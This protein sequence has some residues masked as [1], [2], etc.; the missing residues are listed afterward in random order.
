V[1]RPFPDE[2]KIKWSE[3]KLGARGSAVLTSKQRALLRTWLMGKLKLSYAAIA[4]VSIPTMIE[5]YND[6][7]DSKLGALALECKGDH[8]T[9]TKTETKTE[10]KQET[11]TMP[12]TVT[13]L[14]VTLDKTKEEALRILLAGGMTEAQVRVIARQE[15]EKV[16]GPSNLVV[17]KEKL[18]GS[19]VEYKAGIAHWKLPLFIKALEARLNVALIGPAGTG[20]TTSAEIA[21]EVLGLPYEFT[22]ACMM[23][24]SLMGFLTATGELAKTAFYRSFVEKGGIHLMDEMD[25]WE[26]PALLAANAALANGRASFPDRLHDKHKDFLAVAGMNTIGMGSNRQY[27]GRKAL[28]ASTLDRFAYLDWPTDSALTASFVGVKRPQE[29][30]DLL[31]GGMMTPSAW[32]DRVNAVAGAVDKLGLRHLVTPRA[33]INGHKLFTVGV[34]RAWVEEM[35]LWKGLDSDSRTKV[36]KEAK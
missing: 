32:L 29:K 34:G 17:I 22:G 1:A 31:L 15:A 24:S 8:S 10:T 13:E 23:P 25:S 4:H 19:K 36:E 35:V 26:A 18:D 2:A 12:E 20:K 3:G 33:V 21:A 11:P 27:V 16:S 14:P 30:M 9:S 7:T 5:A 6:M 28:D